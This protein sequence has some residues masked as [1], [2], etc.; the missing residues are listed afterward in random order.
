MISVWMMQVPVHQIIDMVAMR[1]RLVAATG[2]VLMSASNF[3]CATCGIGRVDSDDMLVDVIAVHV[4]HM[5]VVQIVDVA[6]VADGG[7]PAVRA[8]LVRVVRMVLLIA[9]GHGAR[10]FCV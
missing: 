3:R 2:P 1:D 4:V 5:A 7:V 10:S 9:I 8:V 6:L